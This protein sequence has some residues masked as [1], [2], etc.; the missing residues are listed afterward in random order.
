MRRLLFILSFLNVTLLS[1]P[2][3][4][5][6]ELQ[7]LEERV[8]YT[9]PDSLHYFSRK[10]D[11]ATIRGKVLHYWSRGKAYY[12]QS[13]YPKA[14]YE[15]K[16]AARWIKTMNQ[17]T[18]LAELF[19]DLSSSLSAVD[20]NGKALSF[21]LDANATTDSS[22]N[23]EQYL[24]AKISLGEMYR[25]IQE[26]DKSMQ[27][28]KDVSHHT[29]Q[30]TF[31]QARCL[32]RIA[33][34]FS[35]TGQLDS[36][37]YYSRQ[38]L[39]LAE[40]I[41]HADLIA[42]AENEIGYVYRVQRKLK[43]SLPH[44][45]RADSLWRSVGMLRYAVNAMHH[46][47]IVYG[48][49]GALEKS[50]TV[51][52]KALELIEGKRWYQLKVNLL[53]D[54]RN[55][56]GQFNR[57]DSMDYYEQK[58]LKAVISKKDQD[59]EVNTKMVEVLFSQKQNEQTIRE[60]EI[61]LRNEQLEKKAINRER[62]FLWITVSLIGL[63]LM[64]IFI[65][66]HKQ[67]RLKIKLKQE[68]E[69]KESKNLQLT[70]ALESNEALVQEISHRVKNNL[71]VLSGLL[72]MQVDR[73]ENEKV[74]KELRDSIL[75]IDSIATIHKNLYD[76]R[77][78]AKVNLKKAL[79]ELSKN[80]VAALGKNPD[81]ILVTDLVDLEIEIAQA[82]TLCLII[83]EAITNSCKYAHVSKNKKLHIELKSDSNNIYCR[84]IDHGPGFDV[85]KV[86]TNTKS[87][88]VYL[89]K[90]L[91][92]QLKSRFE[93]RKEGEQFILN[94]ELKKDEHV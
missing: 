58:R 66:A 39:A 41:N 44:F 63:S 48:T 46:I 49:I 59:Y 72:N 18:L 92:K 22:Q 65:Y 1:F 27:T 9:N 28:L 61:S 81:D 24:E 47:S 69:E 71:A 70:H 91:A 23:K 25:K 55:L 37:L 3:N 5:F 31:H 12:W 32:N 34:V 51:T 85:N 93:W 79:E 86:N 6:E 40:S 20:R 30:H 80:V 17:P 54:L 82:V 90:L 36:A 89:I 67:R 13:N 64:I 73:S 60:Q 33:A 29:A 8:Q 52:H 57:P 38:S 15:L 2:H 42:T 35:E 10:I 56:Q 84:V 83:N 14:Y 19:L 16:K 75:R 87:L 26:Y 50:L 74:K 78:D 62:F 68:N 53:E 94:I 77:N 43:K 88:G 45:Q 21:L 7:M 76:K 4:G 11:T